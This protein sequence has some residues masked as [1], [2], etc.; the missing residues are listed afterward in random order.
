MKTLLL[1]LVVISFCMKSRAQ[2]NCH[3][4][5]KWNEHSHIRHV[6]GN[7]RSNHGRRVMSDSTLIASFRPM[8]LMIN[9]QCVKF[10]IAVVSGTSEESPILVTYL[11]GKN[12]SGDDNISPMCN[13][14]VYSIYN[15]LKMNDI[16]A[17]MLVPQCPTDFSWAEGDGRKYFE[18]EKRYNHLVKVLLDECIT[19][20]NIDESR[21]YILGTSMG[22][23]GVYGMLLDYPDMFAA[24][25][26]ASG[27]ILNSCE[28]VKNIHTPIYF[29][30]GTCEGT[31]YVEL[32]Q[33]YV[34]TLD[35]GNI[36]VRFEELKGLNHRQACAEAFSEERLQWVF[37]HRR[38][39]GH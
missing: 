36:Q 5:D 23:F 25:F 37:S 30:I 35:K 13:R 24:A 9:G 7:Q 14:G 32:Y 10:R 17:V 27:G 26:C 6:L 8:Q 19:H 21:I 12:A 11:H 15:Y 2:S 29:T 22:G 1:I 39:I 4:S 31:N 20:M 38:K 18:K 16:N 28:Q 33:R 3:G 34:E